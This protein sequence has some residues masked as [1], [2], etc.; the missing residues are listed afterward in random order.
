MNTKAKT[1]LTRTCCALKLYPFTSRVN[2]CHTTIDDLY[3]KEEA[4]RMDHV[5]ATRLSLEEK[6]L[7]QALAAR[8]GLYVSHLIRAVLLDEVRKVFRDRLVDEKDV[9]AE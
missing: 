3:T 4:K 9:N 2:P 1:H 5:V 6:S 7:V 8:R